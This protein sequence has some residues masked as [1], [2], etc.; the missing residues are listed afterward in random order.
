MF[1]PQEVIRKKRDKLALNQDE[2]QTFV[3]GMAD[4]TVSEGQAA[5]FAMATFLNGMSVDEKVAL[6]LAMKH[7]GSVLD[8]DLPGPVIDKHSTGGVGDKVSLMLAPLVAACGGYV[9]MIAGRG[10]GHTGG[11]VDKLEAIPGYNTMPDR[12]VFKRIVAEQRC[13]VVGQTQDLA[14]ADKRLYGIRDVTA[15]VESIPLI[16]ASILSK[17]LA[18]GLD[19]LIM[20]VK[21]GTGA[22]MP[23]PEQAKELAQSIVDVANGAGVKT[24]ALITDMNQVLGLTAGN[25]LEIIET[26]DYLSGKKRESRLHQITFALARRMLT[27][28]GLASDEADAENQLNRALDSGRAAE[29]FARSCAA[30]GGPADLF[31]K[32]D[33]YFE[34]A[35]VVIPYV[36]SEKG[37]ISSMNVREIGMT[38]VALG[39]GRSHPEQVIDPRVGLSDILGLGDAVEQ[40]QAMCMIHAASQADAQ[41]AK[42][43]LDKAI[44]ISSSCNEIPPL[45]H[46]S[47]GD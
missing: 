31:E 11:T 20:D 23:T 38:V 30:L 24:Q 36:A 22:M 14:P 25:S 28:G 37:V 18:A 12:D 9:P 21:T 26:L 45:I 39:G 16:T 44:E 34:K 29:I 4:G 19:V 6:T 7:S 1:I 40:G 43:R 5:A 13:A 47:L 10:L 27:A 15:T 33:S 35:P 2:I 17:K 8:W 41:E 3:R 46:A 42:A 32:S